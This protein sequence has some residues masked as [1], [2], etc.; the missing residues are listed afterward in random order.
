MTDRN[1]EN[2]TLNPEQGSDTI[3]KKERK[4]KKKK[5]RNKRKEKA[6]MHGYVALWVHPNCVQIT[7]TDKSEYKRCVEVLKPGH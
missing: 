2:R 7:N 4:K 1:P 5:G 6:Q 3:F